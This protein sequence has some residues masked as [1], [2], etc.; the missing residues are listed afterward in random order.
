MHSEASKLDIILPVEKEELNGRCHAKNVL[1]N[2]AG[3][4]L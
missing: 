2:Y 1:E 4:L 3:L